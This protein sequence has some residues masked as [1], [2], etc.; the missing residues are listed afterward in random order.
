MV[1]QEDQGNRVH[2]N[3]IDH[4]IVRQLTTKGKNI[5][6]IILDKILTGSNIHKNI[7]DLKYIRDILDQI[8]HKY[9]G[10]NLSKQSEEKYLLFKLLKEGLGH[11]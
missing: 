3:N 2:E 6:I 1:V 4:N 10:N 8:L 9:I 5:I 7:I 11:N